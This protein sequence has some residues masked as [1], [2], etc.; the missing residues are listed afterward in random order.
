MTIK[1]QK[2]LSFLCTKTLTLFTKK[3]WSYGQLIEMD[4][5]LRHSV[6]NHIMM[7][8]ILH[9]L[10]MQNEQQKQLGVYM[11]KNLGRSL[12]DR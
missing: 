9:I 3:T 1:N 4:I 10:E 11:L 6:E 8:K 2:K 12:K 5:A 7:F